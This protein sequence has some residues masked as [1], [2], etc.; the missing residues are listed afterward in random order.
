MDTNVLSEA[1][2]TAPNHGV[3]RKL[4]DHQEE[5]AT[6]SPV[7]HELQ[8]GCWRLPV[9]RKRSLIEKFLS[10]VIKS[11][12]VILPYDATAADWHAEQRAKLTNAG[13]PPSFVDG[14]IAAIA[15]VNKLIL[16][17]RNTSDYDV[18][19][20]LNIQNWHV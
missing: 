20:E 1:I 19:S 6:A 14:Q 9:S 11:S 15:I 4:K 2:K 18:F 3:M 7:W 8:F 17:T 5:I 12:L 16:V 13:R 10:D